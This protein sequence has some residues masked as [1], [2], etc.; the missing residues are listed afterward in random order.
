MKNEIVSRDA[1][2]AAG[3]LRDAQYPASF[4][5]AHR[6]PDL[7]ALPS[8]DRTL[9]I[10][11]Q[12]NAIVVT[13]HQTT[14]RDRSVGHLLRSVS[15]SLGFAILIVALAVSVADQS[16]ISW[17]SFIIF[18]LA[19]VGAWAY[20]EYRYGKSSP[21]AAVLHEQQLKWDNINYNDKQRW[22]AW[23]AIHG[24]DMGDRQSAFLSWIDEHRWWVIGWAIG[25]S[26]WMGLITLLFMLGV[27]RDW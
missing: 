16:A 10:D 27:F 21:N 25:A 12:N 6:G 26:L 7:P 15:L 8:N 11:Y 17:F 23:G 24:I 9:E 22:R 4:V 14:E 13:S 19:F 18:W 1:Q 3:L 20:G 5:P 2:R